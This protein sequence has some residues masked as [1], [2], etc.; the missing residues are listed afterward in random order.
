MLPMK[1]SCTFS[2]LFAWFRIRHHLCLQLFFLSSALGTQH[3]IFMPLLC[4]LNLLENERWAP[5][6]AAMALSVLLTVLSP[7]PGLCQACLQML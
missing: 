7:A 4:I 5:H 3:A 1:C 2:V 6:I